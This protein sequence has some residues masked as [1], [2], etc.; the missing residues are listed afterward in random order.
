M[1]I[2]LLIVP[3]CGDDEFIVKEK[4]SGDCLGAISK[5]KNG[6]FT[7]YVEGTKIG[8]AKTLHVAVLMTLSDLVQIEFK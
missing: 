7:A 4:V 8:E 3:V 6:S 1:E 2:K 5:N